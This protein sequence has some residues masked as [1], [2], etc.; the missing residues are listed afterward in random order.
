MQV[1]KYYLS[2]LV[3]QKISEDNFNELDDYGAPFCEDNK[4]TGLVICLC[5]NSDHLISLIPSNR[6]KF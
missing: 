4:R 3:S 2:P 6:L 1:L 5:P